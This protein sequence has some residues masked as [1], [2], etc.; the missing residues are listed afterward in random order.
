MGERGAPL[1]T[2]A[3]A[4]MWYRVAR[5]GTVMAAAALLAVCVVA[6]AQVTA[7]SVAVVESTVGANWRG[8][9]DLLVTGV[10]GLSSSVG[11]TDG[12][13]EQNFAS[14]TGDTGI[15]QDQLDAV[16][17]L[18][19]VEV[20]APLA[21]VGQLGSPSYGLLVGATVEQGPTSDFFSEA[22]AFDVRVEVSTS[23]GVQMQTVA[24]AGAVFVTGQ[25]DGWPVAGAGGQSGAMFTTGSSTSGETVWGVDVVVPA[26][27]E[28]TA[29]MIA[30]DPIAEQE[31][32][33]EAGGFLDGLAAFDAGQRGGLDADELAELID[34]SHEYER[35]GVLNGYTEGP[36][37]AVVVSDS[38]YPSLQGEVSITPIDVS[39]MPIEELIDIDGQ[40]VAG[41]VEIIDESPRAEPEVTSVDLTAGLT[42]F[43]LPSLAVAV[44]GAD[45]APGGTAMETTP[46]LVPSLVGQ[47]VRAEPT[48]GQLA[49][50]PDQ[51]ATT[52]MAQPQGFA[53]LGSHAAEQTYRAAE[54]TT[55]SVEGLPLYAPVGTYSPR[56]V[57]G[58]ADDVSYVPLGT[59]SD[60]Q[61]Q[62]TQPGPHQGARLEPSFSGRGA[63]LASPGAITTLSGFSAL[64]GQAGAD[65]IRVRVAGIEDYSAASLEAIGDVAAQISDLGLEVRV[66]AGSSLAPVGVYLPEFFTDGDLG[67]TTEEWTSLGAAVQVESAQLGA[68]LALLIVTL[69]GVGALACVV[70]IAGTDRRR[71]E[72]ALLVSLGWTR[73]CIRRWFLAEDAPSLAVVLAAAAI[74]AATSTSMVARAA[75]LG[76]AVLFTLV[77]VAGARAA[78]RVRPGTPRLASGP[79]R[80]SR[81]ARQVGVRVARAHRASGALSAISVVVLTTGAVAFLATVAGARVS[82]GVSRLAAL[83]G[84]DLLLPQTILA[85]GALIAGTAMFVIG[86][87]AGLAGAG[88]HHAMLVAAGWTRRALRSTVRAQIIAS[89]IPGMVIAVM[90][91]ALIWAVVDPAARDGLLT[92]TVSIPTLATVVAVLW[93]TWH[94]NGLIRV[95]RRRAAS[96]ETHHD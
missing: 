31:L 9:Y 3:R 23:D 62:V 12:L 73:R 11:E 83:V 76:V 70:Q 32:L 30:V 6:A 92:L 68:T 77:T 84:A 24:D 81:T 47:A 48:P 8:T 90:A 14:L 4:R 17:A 94:A 34:P 20:A 58:T 5:R 89:M 80:A 38:A 64:R 25:V 43:A 61:I 51:V 56:D 69:A 41:A 50:A 67:W 10:G 78:A 72:A 54:S 39:D 2:G 49:E 46:A 29:G 19:G 60:A 88:V 45:L 37:I 75:A 27:P 15:S 65:V 55:V 36:I 79:A 85:V 96:Q 59:Y 13:V 28:L 66:V 21:F 82:A 44:P 26:V 86:V 1:L 53:S 74:A 18:Q 40:V 42:P 63:A 71:R 57:A 52:V 16:G 93:A 87:R 7:R 22:R 35:L 33:G 91:G 95:P